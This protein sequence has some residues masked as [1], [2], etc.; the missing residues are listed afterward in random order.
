M[1]AVIPEMARTTTDDLIDDRE[2][3]ARPDRSVNSTN[4]TSRSENLVALTLVVVG[5][6]GSFG[7]HSQGGRTFEHCSEPV[8]DH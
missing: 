8:T 5:P 4:W 2:V 7:C 3:P 1:F 6:G